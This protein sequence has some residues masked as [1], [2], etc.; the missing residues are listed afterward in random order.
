MNFRALNHEDIEVFSEAISAFFLNMTHESAVVRTAYLLDGSSAPLWSDFNGMI[1]VSGGFRGSIT[2]SAPHGMLSQVLQAIGERE[3]SVDRCLDVVGEIA[4]M[5]SGRA[6]RHFGEELAISPPSARLRTLPPSVPRA[7]GV[8]FAIPLRWRTH[9]ANL[10][11]HL[12]I[13]R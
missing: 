8:P 11:V 6:R 5:M 2:F 4:N 9:E 10:V 12:D 7:T 1:D 3:H 13:R